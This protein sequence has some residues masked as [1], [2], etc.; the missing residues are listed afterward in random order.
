MKQHLYRVVI[1]LAKRNVDLSKVPEYEEIFMVG[2][3]KYNNLIN[4]FYMDLQYFSNKCIRSNFDILWN[5]FPYIIFENGQGLG[6]DKD[7]GN[8]WHTTSKTGLYNPYQML[9]DKTDFDTEVCYV[10]RSYLTRHGVGPLEEAIAKEK[11][12]QV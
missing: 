10:T 6:L 2:S 4:N 5:E 8:D 11:S 12:M 9:K 3:N 7:I 1:Q